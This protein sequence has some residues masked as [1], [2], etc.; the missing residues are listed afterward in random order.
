LSAFDRLALKVKGS[1][2]P[3]ARAAKSMMGYVREPTIVRLPQ[4]LR[5]LLRP[6]YFLHFGVIVAVRHILIFY[7]GPLF[8]ARCASF[9]RGVALTGKLPFVSGPVEIH[10]GDG[11]AFGGNIRIQSGR[12]GEHLPGLTFMDR[13]R[14]SWNVVIVVNKEIVVEE[15]VWIAHDVRISDSEGHRRELDLRLDYVSPRTEDFRP[16]RICRGAWIGNGAHIMK[17]VTIGEGAVIGANSV[18]MSDVPA[19]ALALG[20]P[21]E[22]YIRG[23]GKPSTAR[24]TS[25]ATSAIKEQT[26]AK[27]QAAPASDVHRG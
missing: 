20:N 6:L 27:A 10:V 18:V 24:K 22:V 7:R 14:V 8:Q 3:S 12:F 11:V 9:G 17:G 16:V 23:F 26:E 13:S 21:A 19:F 4:V 1:Q 5:R 25:P 2:S 15:D